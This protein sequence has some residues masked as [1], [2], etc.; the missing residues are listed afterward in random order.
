MPSFPIGFFPYLCGMMARYNIYLVAICLLFA[1][2]TQAQS[3]G[4]MRPY[5]DTLSTE[6]KLQLLE[7]M[8]Y[9]GSSIDREV[10]Q[11]YLQLDKDKQERALQYVRLQLM[12]KAGANDRTT[13]RFKQDT[14][15]MGRVEEGEIILDSF[16]VT[17]TGSKPYMIRE[18]KTTCDCTVLR[19]PMFPVMPGE[20]VAIRVEFD[21]RGKVGLSTPGMVI[22]DNTKPN[23]RQ[24]V[25][26]SAEVIPRI[27]PKDSS[28]N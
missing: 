5:L 1:A 22:Y 3:L 25:Y 11:S 10:A 19:R 21:T 4:E 20:T 23:G 15:Q 26:L 9:Q 27:K 16:M 12:K 2:T 18:I 24:I 6:Q 7:Y 13:V 8:R 17:N 14:L 28:G